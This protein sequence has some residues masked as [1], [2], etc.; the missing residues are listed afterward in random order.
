MYFKREFHKYNFGS[1]KNEQN[2]Y[3]TQLITSLSHAKTQNP[4]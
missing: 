4:N 1:Q 3:K 2:K